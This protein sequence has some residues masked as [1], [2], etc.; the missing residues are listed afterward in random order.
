MVGR[1]LVYLGKEAEEVTR[2]FCGLPHK[3]K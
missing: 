2:I 3:I 1:T